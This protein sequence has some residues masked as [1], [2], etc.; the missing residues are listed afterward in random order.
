MRYVVRR[1]LA[2]IP[3]LLGVLVIVF[4]ITRVLPGDPA[5]TLAGEQADASTV[6][7]IR[8]Q[9][10]LDQPL[11]VQFVDYVVGI[12]HGDFGYAWHT[13]HTVAEDMLT[14]L[15]ATVELALFALGIAVV[16]GVPLGIASAV[17][18]GRLI[19]HITRVIT[20]VG[21][22]MPLFWLG[23]LVIYLFYFRLDI[24]PA[25]TGRIGDDVHP[26]TTVTGLYVLDSILSGD[27]VALGS[28]LSHIIWPAMVLA[29]GGV[30]MIS[31]MTRSATLEVLGQDYVRT[32]VSKGLP[33]LVVVG[34]HAFRNASPA[35]VTVVG[36]EFGQLLGGAVLTETI[37]S[38]PGVGSY[39]TQS[40]LATDY[41]PVQAFTVLAAAIYLVINLL[42]DLANAAI[43]P[44]VRY[45]TT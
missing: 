23:L 24:A 18:R 4:L 38:W 9:M 31:R 14:R 44:R 19:D 39:V 10:G 8:R 6:E 25:P 21:A 3:A 27:V 16:I 37:F 22:A 45:A 20:L 36:L 15:P 1:I 13:G 35:V 12:L 2:M 42:V 11:H 34:K 33:P 7:L 29:T 17:G 28:A 30:A 40:I 43:D 5:R 32:A 41:A 26:P